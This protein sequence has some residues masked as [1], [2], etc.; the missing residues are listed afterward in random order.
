MQV[1]K[2]EIP[3]EQEEQSKVIRWCDSH[4]D[5]RAALIYSHLNGIRS[6]IG[7]CRKA[8]VSGAR[9]GIPDLFLPVACQGYHGLYVEMKRVKNGVVS[10]EQKDWISQ[11]KSQGYRV[12]VCRGHQAAIDVIQH[13]LGVSYE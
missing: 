12:E 7:A 3:T 10:P 13:Y 6:S 8:K 9:K 11:L 2:T 1:L 4:S 5:R